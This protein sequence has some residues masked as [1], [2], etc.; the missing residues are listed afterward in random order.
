VYNVGHPQPGGLI[1]T[2]IA[3]LLGAATLTT[4]R[5]LIRQQREVEAELEVKKQ[6]PAGERTA[7]AVDL[8]RL[9]ELGL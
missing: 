5:L 7:R 6:I 9:R 4:G 8:D 2:F 1:R 3:R